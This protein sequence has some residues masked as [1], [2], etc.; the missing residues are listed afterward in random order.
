MPIRRDYGPMAK[1]SLD[2]LGT[3][4]AQMIESQRRLDDKIDTLART[5]ERVEGEQLAQPNLVLRLDAPEIEGRS[6]LAMVQ[7]L[8]SRTDEKISILLHEYDGLRGEI[9]GRTGVMHQI[10]SIGIATLGIL[11]QATGWK[12]YAVLAVG[13]CVMGIFS[14]FNGRD[15]RKA[16]KRI[17]Q[18]ESEINRRSGEDLYSLGSGGDRLVGTV[19][20][21]V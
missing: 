13:V 11:T 1:V 7:R 9:T 15:I 18:L 16:A 17:C 20:A 10:V 3:Q 6:G 2:F 19:P 12:L 14:W 4:M 8:N 21:I 5:V